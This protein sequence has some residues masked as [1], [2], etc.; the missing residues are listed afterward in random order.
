MNN[1]SRPNYEHVWGQPLHRGVSQDL[2][3]QGAS[4]IARKACVQNFSHAP[5]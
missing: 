2:K 3:K 5:H 4:P 1:L